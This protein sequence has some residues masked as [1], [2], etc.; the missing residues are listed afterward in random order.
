MRQQH[1]RRIACRGH[2]QT[3]ARLFG[4]GA[5]RAFADRQETGDFLGLEMPGDQ[6]QDFLLT[7]RQAGNARDPALFTQ[8]DLPR[9]TGHIYTA[10]GVD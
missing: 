5:Y 6:A 9:L 3:P 2:A 10:A 1:Q 8:R 7:A 4:M